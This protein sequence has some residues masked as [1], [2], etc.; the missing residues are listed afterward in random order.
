MGDYE[1]EFW[2]HWSRTDTILS[3]KTVLYLI[4]NLIIKNNN[5]ALNIG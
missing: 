2:K 4:S 3:E 5:I 1:N